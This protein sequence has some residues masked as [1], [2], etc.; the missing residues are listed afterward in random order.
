MRV[1]VVVVM[2][3]GDCV[4]RELLFLM[5]YGDCV[6]PTRVVFYDVPGDRALDFLP[7][8]EYASGCHP[9]VG[10]S[11]RIFWVG[12]SFGPCRFWMPH[13]GASLG[14]NLQ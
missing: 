11:D 10:S 6:A 4:E 7:A 2:M 8:L 14:L 3:Y 1:I 12:I 9:E 5:V 13:L